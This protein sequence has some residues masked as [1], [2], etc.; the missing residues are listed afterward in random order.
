[1]GQVIDT[2]MSTVKRTVK[3]TASTVMRTVSTV[4]EYS[5]I[6]TVLDTGSSTGMVTVIDTVDKPQE[7]EPVTTRCSPEGVK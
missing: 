3:R 5:D 1:M 2:V 4:M 6:G 7:N